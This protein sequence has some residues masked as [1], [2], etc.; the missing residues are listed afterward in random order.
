[1]AAYV[2]LQQAKRHLNIVD[3]ASNADID[4]KVQQASAIIADYL[5]SRV[6]DTWDEYTAPGNVQ[7]A[8]LLMVTHLSEHRGDDMTGDEAMWKAIGRLLMRLRDPA[9]A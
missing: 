4:D 1:M 8:T 2:T 6:D 3:D 7:A 9:I 5:K